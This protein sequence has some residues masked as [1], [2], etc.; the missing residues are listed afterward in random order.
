MDNKVIM[1][2]NIQY[3]VQA[4]LSLYKIF[5]KIYQRFT[6]AIWAQ[7]PNAGNYHNFLRIAATR[8]AKIFLNN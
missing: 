5:R 1:P 2:G 7:L 6:G 4:R 3:L 8:I